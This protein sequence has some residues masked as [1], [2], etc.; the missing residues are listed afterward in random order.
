MAKQ[1]GFLGFLKQNTVTGSATGTYTTVTQIMT[2]TA[3]GSERALI[4]VSAHG[5]MWADFLAGRQEGNEVELTLTWDPLN[6]QH[7]NLKADYDATNQ[8]ARYYELQ[9]PNW[10]SAYRFPSIPTSWEVEA[11]DDAGMEAHISLKIVSPGVT[12]VTPS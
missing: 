8:V 11:T 4:D 7:T 2:V 1:A 3:V 9:H 12:T 5:D 10:A 6:T